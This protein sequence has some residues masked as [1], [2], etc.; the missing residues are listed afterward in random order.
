MPSNAARTLSPGVCGHL[1]RWQRSAASVRSPRKAAREYPFRLGNYLLKRVGGLLAELG[2]IPGQLRA[3]PQAGL[4]EQARDVFL[5]R[6][7]RQEHLRG[8]FAVRQA[9]SDQREHVG[10]PLADVDGAQPFWEVSV[11]GPAPRHRRASVPQQPAA[12][13]GDAVVTAGLE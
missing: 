4:G 5:H 7:R 8:Y 12:R 2:E 3:A 13:V 9:L 11:T 10:L 1:R 6:P